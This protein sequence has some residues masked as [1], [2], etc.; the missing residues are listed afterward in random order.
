MHQVEMVDSLHFTI[1]PYQFNNLVL[2]IALSDFFENVKKNISLHLAR[3]WIEKCN[4]LNL[5]NFRLLNPII[6]IRV[7]SIFLVLSMHEHLHF[8]FYFGRSL[9]DFPKKIRAPSN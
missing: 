4:F 9:L 1:R 5:F 3:N 2:G 7:C 6:Y 8:Y